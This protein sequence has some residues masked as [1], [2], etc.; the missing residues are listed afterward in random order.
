MWVISAYRPKEDTYSSGSMPFPMPPLGFL[1]IGNAPTSLHPKVHSEEPLALHY[2]LS[3]VNDT[4]AIYE[5]TDAGKKPP[6]TNWCGVPLI[7]TSGLNPK[8]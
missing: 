6:K 8:T 2:L 3:P 7:P 1:S 5:C 4:E